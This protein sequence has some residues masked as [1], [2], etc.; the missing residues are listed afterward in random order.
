[1]DDTTMQCVVIVVL[2]VCFCVGHIAA[3]R[4]PDD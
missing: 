3:A 4:W 2:T 1:M